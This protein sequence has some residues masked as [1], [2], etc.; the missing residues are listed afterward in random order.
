MLHPSEDTYIH[1]LGIR[2]VPITELP[3][4]PMAG[5]SGK[6]GGEGSVLD[7]AMR[8]VV[9][10]RDLLEKGTRA[11]VSFVRSYKEH[12]CQFIFRFDQLDLASVARAFV[13][14]Q[15][16][17]MKEITMKKVEASFVKSE[18]DITQIRF[19]DKHREKKRQKD[20]KEGKLKLKKAK[21]DKNAAE[22]AQKAEES[23]FAD[24][25]RR[26]KK[27]KNKEIL[28]EWEELAEEERNYKKMK[29]GKITE[30]EYD[31]LLMCAIEPAVMRAA[32]EQAEKAAAKNR[33]AEGGGSSSD[34]SDSDDS[35]DEEE[36]A[37]RVRR[38]AKAARQASG[39]GN[40]KVQVD[41]EE[42]EEEEEDDTSPANGMDEVLEKEEK[43]GQLDEDM[44]AN[45]DNSDDGEVEKPKEKKQPTKSKPQQSQPL[46]PSAVT[47][48]IK[49]KS[50]AT[51]SRKPTKIKV[52]S[53]K[54]RKLPPA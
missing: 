49:A 43:G 2:K 8:E 4:L 26:R 47:K 41:E 21:K 18:V 52:V 38:A 37:A 35:V 17:K 15:L 16:P 12:Q 36:R 45:S 29:A 6:G 20:F 13:L 30:D 5:S 10:D 50:G 53:V 23:V 1:F 33:S 39:G 42:E 27:S 19:K 48:K 3:L 54:K 14:L 24:V 11:F 7:Q 32:E 51:P 44:W 31:K 34:D 22:K 40:K 9:A 28:A 46:K 25:P